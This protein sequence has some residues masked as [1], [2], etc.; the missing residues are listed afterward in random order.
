MQSQYQRFDFFDDLAV[1]RADGYQ[2]N[3]PLHRH[4]VFSL[5]LTRSG[6]ETTIVN[7]KELLA[8][9][10]SISLTPPNC[11]HANPNRNNGVYDFTTFYLSPDLMTY[12]ND[13]LPFS[14]EA[15][16][17]DNP[18]LFSSLLHWSVEAPA[19]AQLV[20]LLKRGIV[21]AID[22]GEEVPISRAEDEKLVT[23]LCYLEANLT[24]KITLDTLAAIAGLSPHHFL[25]WFRA[26]K[27]ITPIQ[28]VNLRRI[29][30]ARG[31][32]ASGTPLIEV[33][34][35]LGFYDQ[36]HFHRFFLRYAGV[37]PGSFFKGSNIVQDEGK[38]LP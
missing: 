31:A 33:A 1:L 7:G 13:G 18:A 26:L 23:V 37:T 19:P 3:F 15:V 6:V 20:E 30:Q 2:Q 34:H 10:G 9:A 21:G 8:P 22:P 16:V 32:L 11:L 24:E 38:G 28:Y 5:T 27:G 17:I 29:E 4:D 14:P 25:R 35:A 36:S 12:L